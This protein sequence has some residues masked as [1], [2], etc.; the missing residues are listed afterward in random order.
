MWL[1]C[2]CPAKMVRNSHEFRT[3]F[4]RNSYEI[5]ANFVR[6]LY[7][8]R[9]N[10]VRSSSPKCTVNVVVTNFVRDS[11]EFL[12]ISTN[13]HEF[14]SFLCRTNTLSPK[15]TAQ[16]HNNN[17]EEQHSHPISHSTATQ[18]Q[19]RRTTQPGHQQQS[20][21]RSS[22]QTKHNKQQAKQRYQHSRKAGITH[23]HHDNQQQQTQTTD[24]HKLQTAQKYCPT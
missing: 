8:L 4:V 20:P 5:R 1:F 3:K 22:R 9:A 16:P 12:R 11:H 18:Q 2:Q 23:T 24:S 17:T 14:V 21:M 15:H 6:I 10:F 13:L 19:H 7:E